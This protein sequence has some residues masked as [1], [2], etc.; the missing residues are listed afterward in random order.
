MTLNDLFKDIDTHKGVFYP[1]KH[2]YLDW[3]FRYSCRFL[4]VEGLHPVTN[5]DILTQQIYNRV[6]ETAEMCKKNYS[7]SNQLCKIYVPSIE[8][9]DELLA[10][11]RGK[12]G[13]K[14]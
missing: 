10:Y 12:R 14:L 8:S 5:S 13:L 1:D 11:D 7:H 6:S 9:I 3:V 2:T 4:E